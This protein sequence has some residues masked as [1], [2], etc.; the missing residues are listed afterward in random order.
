MPTSER[1][2]TLRARGQLRRMLLATAAIALSFA[3]IAA[4]MM[5]KRRAAADPPRVLAMRAELAELVLARKARIAE[6]R[7]A[8]GGTGGGAACHPPS[9]HELS[10]L[11]VMD[12]QFDDAR[13]FAETYE[14][15]CGEDPVVRAWGN[16]PKPRPRHAAAR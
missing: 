7:R 4:T 1:S 3:G 14:S 6:L 13:L 8:G 11:L 12:G 5:P 10:R 16:A 15:R 2:P 9:A